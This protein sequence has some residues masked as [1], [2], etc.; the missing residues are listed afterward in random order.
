[1]TGLILREEGTSYAPPPEG[2][3]LAVCVDVVDLGEMRSEWQGKVSMK[4]KCRIVFELS[5]KRED[6]AAYR[7]SR[8]FTASLSE[9]SNLRAFLQS[10]R[11]KP[12]TREELGGF[13]TEVLIGINAI[14]QI[15]HAER[16]DKVYANIDTI[17][18]PMKGMPLL[19]PTGEYVRV[20]DRPEGE[21][22]NGN[23]NGHGE[24]PHD[25]A[26]PPDDNGWM[27][28]ESQMPF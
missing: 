3:F 21:K 6:G 17:M 13:D 23:G 11:G 16:G 2:Q 14:V 28:D 27:D 7:A 18:K 22:Q 4:R 8:M 24:P 25:D 10:W 12:F 1:M 20:K 26:P 19:K 15:V 5:E 9:K